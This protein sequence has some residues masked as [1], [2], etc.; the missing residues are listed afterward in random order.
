[1]LSH[2]SKYIL[3]LA[4]LNCLLTVLLVFDWKIVFE[5]VHS[6]IGIT[7]ALIMFFLYQLFV[8]VFT[9]NKG[10]TVSPRQSINLFLGFKAGKI[11]LSLLFIAIYMIIVK[12]EL[13]PFIVVFAALFF[14]YLL[15]D[16]V[17]WINREKSLMKMRRYNNKEIEKFYA[18][19]DSSIKP[20]KYKNKEIE[21]VSNYYKK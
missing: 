10:D 21:K 14:I 8:I 3:F 12:V 1:M 2:K 20:Y 6:V 9:E 5:D 17:Y 11:I 4:V 16:T 19:K 13:K 15:F 7:F 18:E